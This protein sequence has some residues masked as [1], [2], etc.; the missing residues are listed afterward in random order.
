VKV[1]G[2]LLLVSL[3]VFYGIFTYFF[4]FLFR[5]LGLEEDEYIR[6]YII[7]VRSCEYQPKKRWKIIISKSDYGHY[8]AKIYDLKGNEGYGALITFS[9]QYLHTTVSLAKYMVGSIGFFKKHK[10]DIDSKYEET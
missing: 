2:G 8:I 6:S 3:S 10:I 9:S 5:F 7:E 4:V 1:A